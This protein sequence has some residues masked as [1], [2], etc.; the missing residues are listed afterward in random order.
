[1][2]DAPFKNGE[3]LGMMD[4]FFCF[5]NIIDLLY[6]SYIFHVQ[7]DLSDSLNKVYVIVFLLY[8]LLY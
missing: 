2:D 8:N 6:I 4:S 1:M 7:S 3:S 5:T